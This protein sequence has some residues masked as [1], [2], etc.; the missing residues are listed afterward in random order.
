MTEGFLSFLL[1]S[2][3]HDRSNYKRC[4]NKH[5]FLR[6]YRGVSF[7]WLQDYLDFL[8]LVLN[9]RWGGSQN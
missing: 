7:R 8:A 5:S 2:T 9:N 1:P 3:Y 6:K 4:E